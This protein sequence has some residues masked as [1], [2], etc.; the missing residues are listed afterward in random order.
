MHHL[1]LRSA[2][3][4]QVCLP[5]VINGA[6]ESGTILLAASDE[7]VVPQRVELVSVLP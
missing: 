7:Q 4:N 1:I 6:K 2:L 5:D 3:Q